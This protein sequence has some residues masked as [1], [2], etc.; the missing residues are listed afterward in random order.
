MGLSGFVP[1]TNVDGPPTCWPTVNFNAFGFG[2]GK[3]WM[4]MSGERNPW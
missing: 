1:A 4:A 2:V 3:D